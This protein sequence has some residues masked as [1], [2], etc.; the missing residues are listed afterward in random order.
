[1]REEK[2][3]PGGEACVIQVFSIRDPLASPA[4]SSFPSATISKG[5]VLGLGA[6]A[7]RETPLVLV[8]PHERNDNNKSQPRMIILFSFSATPNS[9]EKGN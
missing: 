4:S 3:E 8:V 2:I 5:R 9:E 1:M 6:L 7:V